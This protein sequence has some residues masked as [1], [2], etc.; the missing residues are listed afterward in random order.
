M[1]NLLVYLN[2]TVAVDLCNG[3]MIHCPHSR[4]SSLGICV[5]KYGGLKVQMLLDLKINFQS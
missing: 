4:V 1:V 5:M 3:M 2:S